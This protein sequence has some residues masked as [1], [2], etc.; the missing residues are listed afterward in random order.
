MAKHLRAARIRMQ[1]MS[2]FLSAY[3]NILLGNPAQWGTVV[4]LEMVFVRLKDSMLDLKK[5]VVLEQINDLGGDD[6]DDALLR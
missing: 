3:D 5:N 4:I 6:N 1:H 2:F